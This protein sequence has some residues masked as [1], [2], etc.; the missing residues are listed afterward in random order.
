MQRCSQ[1]SVMCIMQACARCKHV[2]DATGEH[3][4]A[5]TEN[6]APIAVTPLLTPP[7]NREPAREA[8]ATGALSFFSFLSS[9]FFLPSPLPSATPFPPPVIGL[10]CAEDTEE[11]VQMGVIRAAEQGIKA[12]PKMSSESLKFY[13][14]CTFGL[15]FPNKAW[16]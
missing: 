11:A 10:S 16:E 4:N 3:K 6:C 1:V 2:Q 13:I 7:R 14:R 12:H 5:R 9:P 8:N 15:N